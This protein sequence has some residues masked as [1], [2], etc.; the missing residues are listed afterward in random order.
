MLYSVENRIAQPGFQRGKKV[1]ELL[2]KLG[3]LA[4]KH[5]H[6]KPVIRED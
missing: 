4:K 5:G 6:K 3:F 2:V 1:M